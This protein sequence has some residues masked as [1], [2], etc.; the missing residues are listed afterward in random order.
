M[1]RNK[2]NASKKKKTQD[3][4]GND[5]EAGEKGSNCDNICAQKKEKKN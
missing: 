5:R 4:V 2:A 1:K 3:K